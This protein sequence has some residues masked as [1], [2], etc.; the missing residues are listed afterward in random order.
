MKAA[1][2]A[3]GLAKRLRP[4]TEEIPKSLV[5]VAGKPI[6]EWQLEWLKAN[7]IT[8]VIILAGYRYEKL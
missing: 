8:T 1:I 4:L 3:G 6:I 7:N 2:I 5:E